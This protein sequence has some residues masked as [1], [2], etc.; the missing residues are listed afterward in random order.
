MGPIASLDDLHKS[1]FLTST[2]P[3]SPKPRLSVSSRYTNRATAALDIKWS[4]L[5]ITLTLDIAIY[6]YTK[7]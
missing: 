5:Q 3:R 6:K 2:W 1:E 7:I 4:Q